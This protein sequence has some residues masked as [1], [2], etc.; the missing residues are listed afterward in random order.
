MTTSRDYYSVLIRAIAG[1]DP[2]TEG[3]RRT[4]YNRA[5]DAIASARL[6]PAEAVSE[7]QALEEAIRKSKLRRRAAR[8]R[9]MP[10]A[11]FHPPFGK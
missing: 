6:S 3:S 1:L 5:R 2:N 7:R 10:F 11:E 9:F 4:L 8:A